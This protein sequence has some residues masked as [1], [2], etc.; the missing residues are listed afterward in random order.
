MDQAL[1]MEQ[2]Y[3]PAMLSLGIIYESSGETENAIRSY[4]RLLSI[5]DNHVPALN[6]LAWIYATC[7]RTRYRAPTK[8]LDSAEQAAALNPAPHILDTLAESYHVNGLH[9]KAIGT[10]KQA[11]ARGPKERDYYESQLRKF[12]KATTENGRT[13]WE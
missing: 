13:N 1:E 5:A 2:K 11:L 12:E 4:E 6:N 3:V 8:A 10:I 7:D 9:Q